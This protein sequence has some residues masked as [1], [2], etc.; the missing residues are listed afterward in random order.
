MKRIFFCAVTLFINGFLL[1]QEDSLPLQRSC[2]TYNQVFGAVELF[3]ADF[4]EN[5]AY[6]VGFSYALPDKFHLQGSFG[7]VSFF[8]NIIFTAGIEYDLW[9]KM[10]QRFKLSALLNYHSKK[11]TLDDRH[12]FLTLGT[13]YQIVFFKSVG[14]GFDYSQPVLPLQSI[15]FVGSV[16]LNLFHTL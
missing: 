16:R 11:E 14:V 9:Q 15:R 13:G 10:H 1:S 2:F 4:H 5:P 12:L 6:T 8:S 3:H 7:S